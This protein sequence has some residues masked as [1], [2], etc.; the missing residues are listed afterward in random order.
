M[1]HDVDGLTVGPIETGKIADG[2]KVSVGKRLVVKI[3]S[4]P[5]QVAI[6]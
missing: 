5:A 6:I 3:S 4:E 2:K 1:V